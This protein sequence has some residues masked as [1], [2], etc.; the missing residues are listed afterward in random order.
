MNDY[1][2]LPESLKAFPRWTLW[3]LE[4]RKEG[5]KPAKVPYL[6]NGRRADPT[7]PSHQFNFLTCVRYLEIDS[8]VE[9]HGFSGIGIVLYPDCGFVGIDLDD[10]SGWK[11]E[12]QKIVDRF[13]GRAYMEKSP[14]GGGIRIIC[15]G[16]LPE[17]S[18][19]RSKKF[20]A[21]KVEIYDQD[22]FLTITG[23]KGRGEPSQDLTDEIADF[24]KPM[25]EGASLAPSTG[26]QDPALHQPEK[27]TDEEVLME[28]AGLASQGKPGATVFMR[29][30]REGFDDGEDPSD[31]LT[32]AISS[33]AN[34]TRNIGQVKRILEQSDHITSYADR[35]TGAPKF[36]RWFN[37]EVPKILRRKVDDIEAGRESIRELLHDVGYEDEFIY[38]SG[39]KEF[40]STVTKSTHSLDALNIKYK[41]IHTGGRGDPLIATILTSDANFMENRQVYGKM[42]MPEPYG[43]TE[44]L[45]IEHECD[46]YVNTWKGF[47]VTPVKGSVQPWLDLLEHL[48]PDETER[49]HALR[50]IAFDVQFPDKKCNWHIVMIGVYGA[51]KDSLLMPIARIFGNAF[52]VVGNDEIKSPYDDGF[53]R[54][55]II[56]VN[57]VRGLSGN[58][59]EKIKRRA[60]TQGD[61]WETLNIKSEKQIMHPNLWSFYFLTNHK[62]AMNV[63]KDERR[64]FVTYASKPMDEDLQQRYFDWLDVQDGPAKLFDFLLGVDLSS[65]N[66]S[67]V[68]MKT[69][70]F[71]EMVED[72][73]S[74]AQ[75][76]LD[77]IMVDGSYGFEQGLVDVKQLADAIKS[78]GS[79][80]RP[81]DVKQFLD[82]QK[83]KQIEQ[84]RSAVT[85]VNGK[86]VRLPATLWAPQ[87]SPLHELEG[88]ELYREVRKIQQGSDFLDD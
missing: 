18:R 61:V 16:S 53:A 73:K 27:I 46:H 83:W 14:S 10:I 35:R 84:I 56:H 36:E 4:Q 28:M 39:T 77:Q 30:M 2:L 49:E 29:I 34:V 72:S 62:D 11:D 5:E 31:A 75:M 1:S 43:S 69:K 85:K 19:N 67:R 88:A 17:N 12:A 68:P 3:K 78:K 37:S 80:V 45:I 81:A 23:V 33:L 52:S 22:R 55:K 66:R 76:D 41:H 54:R 51:G 47:R 42:W 15:K 7:N 44:N 24:V 32:T 26:V 82:K 86:V 50:R 74:D 21:N 9:E 58:A 25:N 71:L 6:P 60:A 65:F 64:F 79:H 48:I 57:E 8:V 20:Y 70:A 40:Y 13:K 87:D 38:I 63:D 59:L